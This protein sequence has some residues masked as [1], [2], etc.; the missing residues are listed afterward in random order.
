MK[1]D[2]HIPDNHGQVMNDMPGVPPG[3][4]GLYGAI[5]SRAYD[6]EYGN[7]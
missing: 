7:K 3:L 1:K 6:I 5:D 4:N 2:H